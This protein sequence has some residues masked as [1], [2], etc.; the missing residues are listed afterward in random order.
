M[1]NKTDGTDIKI[2]AIAFLV[3]QNMIRLKQRKGVNHIV[4][5]NRVW[6]NIANLKGVVLIW[7]LKIGF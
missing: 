2:H 7:N 5:I 3:Y 6:Y 4:K 1:H